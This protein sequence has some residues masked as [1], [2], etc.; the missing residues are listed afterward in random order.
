MRERALALGGHVDIIS[1]PGQG[2]GIGVSIPLDPDTAK[3]NP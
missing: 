1:A 2:T 3:E